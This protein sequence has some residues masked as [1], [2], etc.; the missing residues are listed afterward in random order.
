MPSQQAQLLW[1]KSETPE[2]TRHVDFSESLD[3][4]AELGHLRPQPE[5]TQDGG[6]I[7]LPQWARVAQP[8]G[9]DHPFKKQGGRMD[10]GHRPG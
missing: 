10:D 5:E 1:Q 8:D 4:A 2:I 9:E 3:L 7:D 6:D